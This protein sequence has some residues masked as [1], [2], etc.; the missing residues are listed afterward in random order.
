MKSILIV[1]KSEIQC[2]E[3]ESF[4]LCCTNERY[5]YVQSIMQEFLSLLSPS[6]GFSRREPNIMTIVMMKIVCLS[7]WGKKYQ[8]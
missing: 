8:L 2:M 5:M 7:T 3:P 1:K 6:K 4:L